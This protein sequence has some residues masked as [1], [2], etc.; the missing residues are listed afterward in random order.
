MD[1]MLFVFTVDEWVARKDLKY[2]GMPF[3]LG[4]GSFWHK[5]EHFRFLVI[6]RYGQDLEK[7]FLA[8]GRR[9]H[10]KTVLSVGLQV[11]S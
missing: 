9:F 5:E 11:V 7:I 8:R 2:L 4:S 6:P 3:Y 1:G 10:L